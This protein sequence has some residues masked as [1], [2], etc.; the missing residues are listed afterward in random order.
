MHY[1]LVLSD[2]QSAEDA[3]N[4]FY[5]KCTSMEEHHESLQRMLQAQPTVKI[6]NEAR[7]GEEVPLKETDTEEEGITFWLLQYCKINVK[8]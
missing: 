5:S 7:K 3:F 1:F 4:K 8:K 2:E 6:I